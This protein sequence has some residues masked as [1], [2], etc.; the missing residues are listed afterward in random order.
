MGAPITSETAKSMC[1][2]LSSPHGVIYLYDPNSNFLDTFTREANLYGIKINKKVTPK[3]LKTPFNEITMDGVY[4]I[5]YGG[6][7]EL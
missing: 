1:R 4:V 3:S 2:V 5:T 7:D 6:H